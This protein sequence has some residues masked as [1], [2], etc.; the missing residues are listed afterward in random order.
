MEFDVIVPAL[1][2]RS[3]DGKLDLGAT[4]RY[5]IRAA[6][7]WVDSFI[8]SGSTTQGQAM[9]ADD[10]AAVIDL[11]LEVTEP[12]RILACCW[13]AEDFVRAKDRSV[14]PMAAMRTTDQAHS[15]KFLRE[16]PSGATIYSH[17]MFGG[18]LFD[19]VLARR[20]SAQGVLPAG[21]KLAKVSASAIA[22]I[23]AAVGQDF[24]LWD[25]SSRDIVGSVRAGA[26]GVVATPLSAFSENFPTPDV[27]SIQS[28]VDVVQADL[29]ALP[30]RATR[31][32]E[33][34]RRAVE[35]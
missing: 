13:E 30:S 17:P 15:L 32:D 14:T 25:G 11:W 22:E 18:Q 3:E 7:T 33:L 31:A 23:R 28:A 6:A 21:G 34:L 10:R 4:R 2:L 29:D 26:S 27:D 16:L 8:L 12:S 9:S 1:N 20:A 35:I 5:A 24:R 19:P